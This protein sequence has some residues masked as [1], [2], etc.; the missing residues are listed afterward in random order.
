MSLATSLGSI[1][2]ALPG[3]GILRYGFTKAVRNLTCKYYLGPGKVR[4]IAAGRR[5][6]S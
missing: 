4:L 6:K 5:L 2:P 3:I 1:R